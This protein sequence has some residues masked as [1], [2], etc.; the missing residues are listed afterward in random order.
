MALVV[1]IHRKRMTLQQRR[2]QIVRDAM[3]LFARHG[4]AGTTTQEIARRA[5]I[6]E[7]LLFRV[8]KDKKSLYSAI[9]DQ[10]IAETEEDL[11]PRQAALE[12]RDEEVFGTIAGVLMRAMERD[13]SFVRLLLYSGL[14][15]HQ[16][17]EMFYEARIA[18][19]FS[20]LERYIKKR[21]RRKA[22][23]PV[24]ADL[25]ARAFVGMVTN[26]MLNHEILGCGRS[27]QVDG[28]EAVS[29]FVDLTLRGLLR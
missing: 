22:F 17:A 13:P 12:E 5:G 19:L 20:F 16:L 15:Q 26:H 10:K 18:K 27:I 9:I 6:S 24:R 3:T 14:E 8:F 4:F 28:R 11:F 25:I 21:I 2:D 7:A 1:P 23:R 29:A